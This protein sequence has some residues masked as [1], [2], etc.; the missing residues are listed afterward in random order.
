MSSMY[1]SIC[2]TD[3]PREQMRKIKCKDGVERVYVNV[4]VVERKQPSQYGHTHFISCEPKKEER[5][6]GVNYIF[7]DL[8]EWQSQAAQKPTAAEISAA[9]AV[10]EDE[11]LPF[12]L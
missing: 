7:G 4:R 10:S 6:E 9:P 12:W 1:G 3:I 8:K 2:L 11:N 5:K